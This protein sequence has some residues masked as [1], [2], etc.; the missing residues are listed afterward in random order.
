MKSS[1][2]IWNL[3]DIPSASKANKQLL[4]RNNVYNDTMEFFLHQL[5]KKFASTQVESTVIGPPGQSVVLCCQ[6]ATHK[7]QNA[8]HVY[9]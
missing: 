6:G 1:R 2:K 4:L 9:L 8:G 3:K 5:T 7:T